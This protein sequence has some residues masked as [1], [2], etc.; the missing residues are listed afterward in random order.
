MDPAGLKVD[1]RARR[2]KADRVDAESLLRALQAWRRGDRQ[3]CTFVRVPGVEEEDARRPHRELARLT[4]ERVGHVNRIEALLA[5]HGVRDYRP[6]GRDRREAL[7]DLRTGC[8]EP[9]P[10]RCR[11]EIERELSRLEL[12][13]RHVAEVEADDTPAREAGDMAAPLPVQQRPAAAR[14]GHQQGRQHGRARP[15]GAARLA[16]GA[17]PD[18]QRHH[19]LARRPH[20]RRQP[21][22][23]ARGDR[24]GGAQAARRFVALRDPR[25]RADRREAEARGSGLRPTSARGRPSR[26]DGPA[27]SG[28]D[29]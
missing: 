7:A 15:S 12:V 6:L 24:G 2:V 19:G 25:A 5:L 29:A 17:L 23:P 28:V 16:V 20:G 8:G 27:M 4:K 10:A 22:E 1:R 21:E 14:A 11:L 3:A 9:L 18:R 26:G 13:L